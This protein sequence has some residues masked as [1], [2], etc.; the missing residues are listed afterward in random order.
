MRFHHVFLLVGTVT[1]RLQAAQHRQLEAPSPNEPYSVLSPLCAERPAAAAKSFSSFLED[2]GL[3]PAT[4]FIDIPC[5]ESVVIV[6]SDD[7]IVFKYG[8]SVSGKLSFE[9]NGHRT[10]IESPTILVRGYLE[11]G[12]VANPY[13]SPLHIVLTDGGEDLV[14]NDEALGRYNP[15]TFNEKGLVVVGGKVTMV[16]ATDD[17]YTHLLENVSQGSKVVKV[18][19][20]VAWKAGDQIAISSGNYQ[21]QFSSYGTIIDTESL[22]GGGVALI[23]D[24][25]TQY[26][27]I[28]R[29]FEKSMMED[30]S[31][32]YLR[33]EVVKTNRNIVI[34]GSESDDGE[35]GYFVMSH[36]AEKQVVEGVEFVNMGQ[37]GYDNRFP[38]QVAFGGYVPEGTRIT[39]NSIHHSLQRCVVIQATHDVIVDHNVAYHTHGHCFVTEDG[40]ETGN[41]FLGNVAMNIVM[42]TKSIDAGDGNDQTDSF[43]SAFYMASPSNDIQGNVV[44]GAQ[45]TGFFYESF[46]RV[47]GASAEYKLPG[48]DTLNVKHMPFGVFK[49][50]LA[51]GV[52]IGLNPGFGRSPSEPMTFFGF[53]CWS[54]Y[55][56]FH[57]QHSHN[58]S[59]DHVTAIDFL[60]NGVSVLNAQGFTL[61]NALLVGELNKPAAEECDKR[62][63]AAILISSSLSFTIQNIHFQKLSHGSNCQ[64]TNYAID[65]QS[66]STAGGILHPALINLSFDESVETHYNVDASPMAISILGMGA[67]DLAPNGA[68]LTSNKLSTSAACNTDNLKAQGSGLVYCP[69]SCWKSIVLEWTGAGDNVVYKNVNTNEEFS[70]Y[71]SVMSVAGSEKKTVMMTLPVGRYDFHMYDKYGAAVFNSI[72]KRYDIQQDNCGG[73]IYSN[74]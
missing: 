40:I 58:L 25:G 33:P 29:Y 59:L 46:L 67:G 37:M 66:T 22:E 8:L 20:D 44:A 17:I 31:E 55:D 53:S 39:K 16:G 9:D 61:K 57:S 2:S 7:N 12:S 3:D 65:I 1:A 26:G 32:V 27:H 23:L 47:R 74:E 71:A 68:L 62:D 34:S 18:G 4:Q 38:I 42:S 73:A 14:I 72:V 5:D 49:D 60:S 45:H 43:A 21:G 28:V 70:Q 52:Q 63:V 48:F 13:S 30:R 36:C 19:K 24:E 6:P 54:V 50:N 64:K 51:H 35:G 11:I 56:C 69:N 41:K 15:L 10:R